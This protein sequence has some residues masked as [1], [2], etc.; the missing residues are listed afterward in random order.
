MRISPEIYPNPYT[1][2]QFLEM[3]KKLDHI[4]N[5]NFARDYLVILS[6][7]LE[8]VAEDETLLTKDVCEKLSTRMSKYITE[9]ACAE[10]FFNSIFLE[11]RETFKNEPVNSVN[12]FLRKLTLLSK[13]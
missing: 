1:E 8:S 10:V 5:T 3:S 4:C 12:T 9:S 13:T 7:E 2:D 11:I 6:A